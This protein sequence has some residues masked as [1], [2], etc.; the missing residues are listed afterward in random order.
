MP[1]H[2]LFPGQ[3]ERLREFRD[4]SD[5]TVKLNLPRISQTTEKTSMKIHAAFSL[6]LS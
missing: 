6:V 2:T 1:D 5:A 4:V 3:P